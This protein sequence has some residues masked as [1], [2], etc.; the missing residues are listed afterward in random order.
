MQEEDYSGLE[1]ITNDAAR[2]WFWQRWQATTDDPQATYIRSLLGRNFL[3]YRNA[4]TIQ[5][6]W[7]K[8]P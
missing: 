6:Y 2:D 3:I 1:Y 4:I 8:T 7:F 5:V